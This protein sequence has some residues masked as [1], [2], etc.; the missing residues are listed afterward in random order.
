MQCVPSN[1]LAN[2]ADRISLSGLAGDKSTVQNSLFHHWLE[3]VGAHT[4]A[5]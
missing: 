5:Q 3:T 2:I 4:Y 1:I